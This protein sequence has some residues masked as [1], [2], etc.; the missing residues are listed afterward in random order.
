M[1]GVYKRN[2]FVV[3]FM[4]RLV[5][6]IK[7]ISNVPSRTILTSIPINQ[8]CIPATL[9]NHLCYQSKFWSAGINPGSAGINLGSAGI[10][11]GSAG[12]N[13]GGAGMNLGNA[14]MNLGNAGMNLGNAGINPGG[15]RIKLGSAGTNL[16]I[17]GNNLRNAGNELS[18]KV[19]L[20]KKLTPVF[21]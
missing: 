5:N 16:G 7:N 11:L 21:N 8:F 4:F 12:T 18:R 9:L 17:A 1:T 14:E 3:E 19:C 6:R 15:G 20:F 2:N 13:L 10:N